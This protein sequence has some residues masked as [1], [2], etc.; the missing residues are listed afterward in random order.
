M[1]MA[2][3]FSILL[4]IRILIPVRTGGLCETDGEVICY[5][6]GDGGNYARTLFQN[7]KQMNVHSVG[8]LLISKIYFVKTFAQELA[9]RHL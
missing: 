7:H 8:T 4:V 2:R 9:N 3:S 5:T 6:T 1:S